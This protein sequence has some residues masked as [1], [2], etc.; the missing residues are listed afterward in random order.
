MGGST[1]S[2]YP[3]KGTTCF[4]FLEKTSMDK[5]RSSSVVMSATCNIVVYGGTWGRKPTLKALSRLVA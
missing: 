3:Q 5:P 2:M 4:P 1:F